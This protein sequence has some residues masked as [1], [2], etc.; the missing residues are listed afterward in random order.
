MTR[1]AIVFEE[2]I[3]DRKGAFLAKL[4]RARHLREQEGMDVDV[5][6]IQVS[7]GWLVRKLL[8]KRTLDGQ[9]EAQV[10]RPETL[11]F[12]GVTYHMLWLR[13]SILDHFLFFKMKLRPVLYPRFLKRVSSMFQGYDLMSA[14]S[15]EGAY[16][17]REV[18]RRFG[19]PYCVTW[20]GSD[21]HTKP[22]KYP[23]IRELTAQFMAGARMNF[24]VS[25]AL[26]E[27]SEELGP[28]KKQVLYNG[29]S[30]AFVR[31]DDSKRYELR[32]KY[33]LND[34][35]VVGFVGNL[36][37]VKNA[38]LLPSLFAGIQKYSTV[39][40]DFWV[41]GDGREK[42]SIQAGMQVP[43]RFFGN[44]SPEQMPEVFNCLDLLI[45]PSLNEG[46]P[47]VVLEALNCG[48]RVVGSRVG[49]VPEVLDEAHCVPLGDDF[50]HRFAKS[51]AAT[52]ADSFSQSI[53]A[54]MSWEVTARKE[55][56]VYRNYCGQV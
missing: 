1:V 2:N 15:F 39:N 42:A 49:G 56:E 19:I 13:Y 43:C 40:L 18:Q 9:S 37:K 36:E 30:E 6:C 21:V 24:F 22:F 25:K 35:P 46:L 45:L 50:V 38:S 17:A 10:G 51:A 28:G 8:A 32:K 33:Q 47:L 27:K 3:F 12:D 20:H 11:T 5:W 4:Q 16:L 52:L 48:C 14:H 55:A 7:Y 41:V 31:Y 34:A 44:L 23:C 54:E 53:P 29:C 26:L